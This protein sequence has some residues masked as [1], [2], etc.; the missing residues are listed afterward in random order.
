M[1]T[2]QLSDRRGFT[3]IE[4]L[5]V[6]AI[7][8]VLIALLLPAV[9]AAREAARRAQCTNNLKQIGLALHNYHSA[10]GSFPIGITV[11]ISTQYPP[12]GTIRRAKLGN[13]E[14]LSLMLPYLEQMPLYNA[15]NFALCNQ[16]VPGIAPNATVF[17]ANIATFVCPSDGKTATAASWAKNNNN[18]HGS[19]GTTT[20]PSAQ[21]STGIFA[22]G[23]SNHIWGNFVPGTGSTSAG[24][25][26]QNIPQYPPAMLAYTVADVT[27][28]TSNTVAFSEAVVGDQVHFTPFRDGIGWTNSGAY[29]QTGDAWTRQSYILAGIQKCNQMWSTQQNAVVQ[30]NKGWRGAPGIRAWLSSTQSFLPARP[31]P[32]GRVAGRTTRGGRSRTASMKMPTACIL[33]VPM[34]ALPTAASSSSRAL[35]R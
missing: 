14:R 26:G 17:N 19:I 12:S 8:A 11:A 22:P 34:W 35:S 15:A 3:L 13:L 33:A 7:I 4:L 31:H 30:E 29:Y 24:G 1:N 21:V 2:K 16:L 5:V 6:I 9:Q 20:Y 10:Q 25:T 32:H 27:D 23:T 18:Y 28:G